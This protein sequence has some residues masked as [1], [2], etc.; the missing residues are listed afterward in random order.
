MNA[1]SQS[2][3]KPWRDGPP[4]SQREMMLKSAGRARVTS[5]RGTVN[6]ESCPCLSAQLGTLRAQDGHECMAASAEVQMQVNKLLPLLRRRS[7]RINVFKGT[8]MVDIREMYEKDG[9]ELPGK[10]GISLNTEQWTALMRGLSK[11]NAAI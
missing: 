4:A 11:L 9:E 1:L 10:K 2:L 6:F 8:A 3:L 5:A 7:V